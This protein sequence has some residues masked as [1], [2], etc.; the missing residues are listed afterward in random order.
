VLGGAG[1]MVTFPLAYSIILPA[2][3]LPVIIMLLALIGLVLAD[4][5]DPWPVRA[6]RSGDRGSRLAQSGSGAT[7]AITSDYLK[8]KTG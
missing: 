2:L 4:V 7:L 6:H 5:F 3:Y 8:K 1:L